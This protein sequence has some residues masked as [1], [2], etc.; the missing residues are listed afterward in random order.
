ME[1]YKI[2]DTI[3][4]SFIFDNEQKDILF[5]PKEGGTLE[6]ECGMVWYVEPDGT[7]HESITTSNIIEVGLKRKSLKK[8]DN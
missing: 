4:L 2:I 7:R 8:L 1:K 6:R 5:S 3:M